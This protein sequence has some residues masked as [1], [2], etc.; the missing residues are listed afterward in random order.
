MSISVSVIGLGY[1]G[2][3]LAV[4]AA[5]SGFKVTGIDLDEIKVREINNGKSQIEDIS[6]EELINLVNG[7]KIKAES[8]YSSIEN[9]EIVVIC[10]PTPLLENHL[11][12]LSYLEFVAKAI[13]GRL[14]QES[15]L[16]LEST[17]APGT[18][19]DFLAPLLEF[20]FNKPEKNFKLAF[21][22]ERIDPMNLHWKIKNTPKIV[23]GMTSEAKNLAVKF[24]SKFIDE[25]IECESIEVAET[26]KL[27][28]NSF[29]FI[30]IS[31]IN[32]LSIFCQ[33]LGIN[34]NEV[35]NAAATKPYGFMPFYPSIGIGGHCIPVDPLYLAN[36]AREIGA[37]TRFIDLADHINQEMPAYF[38]GRAE[39]K[40]GGLKGKKVLVIGVSYKPNVA[41][42]RETPVAALILGLKNKG[43][44]VFWHDDLVKEWNAEKSAALS[45]EYDL[46]ILAT[47]HDYL[48]LSKLG[49]VPI[50]NTRGS[51]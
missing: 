22:P 19:R 8:N 47:P 26:A 51:I 50:L 32:E 13:K 25:V 23:A 45:S 48:D 1:V 36:K 31:F 2:L 33:K 14:N 29:R 42:V 21:S 39:E 3:P 17:V 35:V 40:I 24:Y 38:V 5:K 43:A 37:P 27:L 28:E 18:T 4:A 9:S 16:I 15:L 44:E 6:N 46:A 7:G 49:N 12:D 11:P 10:V 30:N 41:D 34:I 20:D